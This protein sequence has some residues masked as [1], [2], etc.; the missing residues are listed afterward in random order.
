MVE[1]E[2]DTGGEVLIEAQE[3]YMGPY[4]WS[5]SQMEEY[6]SNE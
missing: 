3:E 2:T 1:E 5:Q 6:E 4:T